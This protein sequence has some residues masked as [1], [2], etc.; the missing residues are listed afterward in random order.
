MENDIEKISATAWQKTEQLT[1]AIAKTSPEDP[2]REAAKKLN[3]TGIRFVPLFCSAGLAKTGSGFEV[4]L[5]LDGVRG[6]SEASSNFEPGSEKWFTLTNRM[7]FSVA[8]ELA[9]LIFLEAADGDWREGVFDTNLKSIEGGCSSL[10]RILLLPKQ[11]LL[12]AVD[13]Q[14]FDVNLLN[15]ICSRFRVSPEVFIRRLHLSDMT[16]AFAGLD[17]VVALVQDNEGI[18]IIKTCHI[19]GGDSKGRFDTPYEKVRVKKPKD[20]SSLSKHFR[21]LAW[22]IEG[23]PVAKLGIDDELESKLRRDEKGKWEREVPFGKD[24][25][26]TC[27][28][29]FLR[30]RSSPLSVLLSI[31]VTRHTHARTH[32]KLV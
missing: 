1:A 18:L 24:T 19:M 25:A 15:E 2:L 21:Q 3:I 11:M 6:T 17:C 7:R 28:I 16:G 9:H 22:A 13:E 26:I 8:H 23:L 12:K 32:Q 4:V 31:L 14:L 29:R 5:N 10:A 27:E 30:R 20:H